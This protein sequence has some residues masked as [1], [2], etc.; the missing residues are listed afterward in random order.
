LCYISLF[1]FVALGLTDFLQT[2]TLLNDSGGTAYESNPVAAA[3]LTG[4][5]WQGLAVFKAVSVALVAGV[6]VV[7]A[8]RRPKVGAAVALVGCAVDLWVVFH[9]RQLAAASGG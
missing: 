8:R 2:Y 5:G 1:V 7:L 9:T 4:Y 3:W 6:V